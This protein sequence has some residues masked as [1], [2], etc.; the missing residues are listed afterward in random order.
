MSD[1][2]SEVIGGQSL[3]NRKSL[4]EEK[5]EFRPA[6]RFNRVKYTGLCYV[7]K[8]V[9]YHI[10]AHLYSTRSFMRYEFYC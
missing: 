1:L 6:K 5:N 10:N 2:N 8:T 4:R 3:R 7:V 9:L